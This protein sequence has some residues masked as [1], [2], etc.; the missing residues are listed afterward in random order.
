MYPIYHISIRN[1]FYQVEH[2]EFPASPK[3]NKI[4]IDR[5]LLFVEQLKSWD[6]VSLVSDGRSNEAESLNTNMNE[7]WREFKKHRAMVNPLI[8]KKHDKKY[9]VIIGNQRLTCLRALDF[10]GRIPCRIAKPDD[11]WD[12]RIEPLKVHPYDSV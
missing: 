2:P 12:D 6:F 1:L 4:F 10:P 8:V 7:V 9:Y 3:S 11:Y 5:H